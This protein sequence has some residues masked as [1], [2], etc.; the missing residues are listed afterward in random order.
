M[1]VLNGWIARIRVFFNF[2]RYFLFWDQNLN[3]CYL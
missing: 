2:L 3:C 1:I